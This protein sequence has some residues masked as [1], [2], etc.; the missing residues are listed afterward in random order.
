MKNRRTSMDARDPVNLANRALDGELP[1]DE[2]LGAGGVEHVRS[3]RRVERLLNIEKN[4]TPDLT[5]TVL[6]DVGA[7]RGWLDSRS[8]ALVWGGRGLIAATLLAALAVT[9][10]VRRAA[11]EFGPQAR[12]AAALASLVSAGERAA[13]GATAPLATVVETIETGDSVL[14]T[15]TRGI[16]TPAPLAS[17]ELSL[18]K[19]ACGTDSPVRGRIIVVNAELDPASQRTIDAVVRVSGSPR[20]VRA[21]VVG[22]RADQHD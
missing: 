17:C 3:V 4:A 20:W 1:L 14:I 5:A 8:R 10:G 21:G 18:A 2:A 7:R 12:E 19:G 22:L 6:E 15:L 9:L 16:E 13:A 11:P